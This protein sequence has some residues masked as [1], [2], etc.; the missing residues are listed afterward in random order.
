MTG[1]NWTVWTVILAGGGLTYALRASFVVPAERIDSLPAGIERII[2]FVP[3]AV[4]AAL[5][6][7]SLLVQDGHLALSASNTRLVSRWGALLAAWVTENM[8][9]TIA[10]GMVAFWTLRF[11]A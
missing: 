5:V 4:L 1:V 2:E 7:P 9:A 11:V 10:V 8:F 3:A 6:V